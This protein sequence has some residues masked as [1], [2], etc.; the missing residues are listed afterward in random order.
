[1]KLSETEEMRGGPLSRLAPKSIK[2]VEEISEIKQGEEL[3][4]GQVRSLALNS[5]E[6]ETLLCRAK[7][8]S[9]NLDVIISSKISPSE[10]LATS[11]ENRR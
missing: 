9:S 1:M 11:D 6:H 5:E 7:R 3:G 4:E 2:N 8:T 10:D